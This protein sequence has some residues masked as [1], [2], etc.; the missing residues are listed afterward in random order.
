MARATHWPGPGARG[1]RPGMPAKLRI[2]LGLAPVVLLVDQLTKAWVVNALDL[3]EEV[4]VLPGLL[5]ITHVQNPGAALGM[6]D[7]FAWRI[8]LF[9]AFTGVAVVLLWQLYRQ[10][11][12]DDRVQAVVVALVLAGGLGNFVDRVYKQAVTDFIRVY[13]EHPAVQGPLEA[14][15]GWSEWPIFNV[16]DVAIVSGVGLYLGHFFFVERPRARLGRTPA[17]AGGEA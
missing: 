15:L 1:I 3:D 13:T 2:L 6:L 11:A 16:A 9:L 14:W 5:S 10:I 7:D 12:D 17:P 4:Q 8:P